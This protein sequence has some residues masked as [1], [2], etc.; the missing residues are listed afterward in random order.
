MSHSKK[1]GNSVTLQK[2]EPKKRDKNILALSSDAVI[3][4]LYFF[5]IF[6]TI[7]ALGVQLRVLKPLQSV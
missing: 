6:Q 7:K 3:P 5:C 2:N 1:Q 4:S